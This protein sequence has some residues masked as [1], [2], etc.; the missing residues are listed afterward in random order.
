MNRRP[1]TEARLHQDLWL[2]DERLR[3]RKDGGRPGAGRLC[4][5]RHRG[6]RRSHPPQHLPHPREGGREGL[7]RARPPAAAEGR[8]GAAAGREVIVGVAGCVAQAEGA[9]IV[10]RAPVVDLV[11]GPQSYQRLPELLA[12]AAAGRAS[13]RDRVRRRRKIRARSTASVAPSAPAASPP[14]SPCRKAATSSAPSASSPIRAAPRSRGRSMPIVA[15]AARLAGEGVREITLLGQNVNAWHGE[16]PDGRA[17]GLGR[18]LFRLAEIPGLDRLRYTTSHPARHGR[19]ADRGPS[20]PRCADAL[21]ASAGAVGLG[22]RPRRDEPPPHGVPTISASIDRIRAAR[23]DIAFAGDFIVGFPGESEDDFDDTLSI[24]EEVGYAAAF[25]FKYSPRPGHAGRGRRRPGAGS[26]S[27][28][29]ACTRLQ[30]LIADQQTRLQPLARR[31]AS[32]TCS[33]SAGAAIP[34]RSSAARPGCCR[35]RSTRGAELIG[36]IG[37]VLIEDIGANSLF[38]RLVAAGA[39]RSRAMAECARLTRPSPAARAARRSP[40]A[41]PTSSSPST[42]TG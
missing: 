5:G 33:S 29:S 39:D 17:W 21:S 8:R 13:G 22:P 10:R 14:S 24:V 31:H 26:R 18:L 16:G 11:V 42:T 27:R 2:P 25:S 23:P 30:A 28:P 34:A 7:F 19:R 32:P 40:T 4:P 37:R 12:A 20:R 35:S 9:E 38:G 1:G 3:F 15:E 41:A 36:T 6:I